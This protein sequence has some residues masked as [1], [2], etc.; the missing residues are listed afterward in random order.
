MLTREG[1]EDWADEYDD[2]VDES[3]DS[4]TYP[5]CGYSDVH[6]GVF[7]LVKNCKAV[8]DLGVGTA[9]LTSRLYG[10]GIKIFGVDFSENMLKTARAKMPDARLVCADLTEGLPKELDGEK[11]DAAVSLYAIH[12]LT[13]PQKAELIGQVF[14]SGACKR[15]IIGDVAFMTE[16]DRLACKAAA[17]DEFDDDEYYCIFESLKKL[18][19][20]DVTFTR[21]SFC[22]GI[23]TVLCNA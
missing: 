21:V 16:E 12:H 18:L 6:N 20:Y 7:D 23:I 15:F 1:F 2:A 9:R 3:Q 14:K 8:L 11:Y 5:F 22:A 19:P 13:D 10:R 4:G 17:G